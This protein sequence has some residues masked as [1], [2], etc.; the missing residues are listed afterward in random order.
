MFSMSKPI[1]WGIMGTGWV[2]QRFMAD[3]S[4]VAGSELA[5]VASRSQTRADEVSRAF[6]VS[7][8]YGSYEAL[9]QDCDIDVVY[10]ATE[11]HQH[12]EHCRLALSERKHVLCEKPFATS[13]E[14]AEEV[15]ATARS[16]GKFCMEAMWS[17]FLP[18]TLEAKRRIDSG[19]IG[20]ATNL[21]V[22][23][24]IPEF[25]GVDSRFF[26]PARGGGAL[27]DRGV[28]GVS[29]ATWLFGKPT[30]VTAVG[31]MHGSGIDRSVSAILGFSE[32]RI[33]LIAASL[34][35]YSSNQAVIAGTQGRIILKEPFYR[36]EALEIAHIGVPSI[37]A[38]SDLRPNSPRE[39]ARRVVSKIRPY[40]PASLLRSRMVY[41][42]VC[43]YGYGYE[44][45]EVVRCIRE[46]LLESALMPLSDSLLV[47]ST[48]ERIRAQIG[49]K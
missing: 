32:N 38:R 37:S 47:V 11:H 33:A 23:F 1:R 24:G 28:Y 41:R 40:L 25:E 8:A 10:V 7:R 39:L 6:G 21:T 26:D 36:P 14:Q 20:F 45:V 9:A 46:G 44:A 29:L 42:P 27:L 3:L 16:N 35:S 13:S 15:I 2:A 43:G 49:T 30:T 5:A 48:M 22:D 34:G 17:R 4:N 18:G 19:A 31:D 12:A